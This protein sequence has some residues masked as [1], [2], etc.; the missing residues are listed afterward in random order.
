MKRIQ[1]L[2][3]NALFLVLIAI[4]LFGALIYAITNSMRGGGQS[5]SPE[6]A[7]AA[8]GEILAYASSI[9]QAVQRLRLNNEC[10]L[11][12]ISFENSVVGAYTN[13]SAPP[14]CKVFMPSGGGLSWQTPD[15]KWLE[16]Q[17]VA[18]GY[19]AAGGGYG[20]Y[21][22]PFNV[23]IYQ[24]GNGTCSNAASEK[25]LLIGL[26]YLRKDVCDAL[27]T[28]LGLTTNTTIASGSPASDNTSFYTGTFQNGG[29]YVM[30]FMNGK[31]TG[32]VYATSTG[33]TFWHVLEAQ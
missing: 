29:Q 5:A 7:R 33:Y 16:S 21:N 27:N 1:P 23:C 18:N 26:K 25:E 20:R 12:Q 32:C 8:A 30:P 17:T 15:L 22:I 24:L 14:E 3:G 13:G 4:V 6:A 11:Y 10:E 28:Q 31:R 19:T 2:R 9:E